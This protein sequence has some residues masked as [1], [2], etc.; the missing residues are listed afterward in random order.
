MRPELAK[1]I[2]G[3]R[4][5]G[6]LAVILS[7]SG[8]TIAALATSAED[9]HCIADELAQLPAVSAVLT[10]WGA[11]RGAMIEHEDNA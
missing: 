8:P 3:A 4:H 2:A 6:A 9:A 5:A 7:G 1:T 10:T 11:A